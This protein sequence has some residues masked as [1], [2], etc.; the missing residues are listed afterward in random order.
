MHAHKTRKQMKFPSKRK[1]SYT[2]GDQQRLC[3]CQTALMELY[4]VFR[5]TQTQKHI[6]PN[7]PG[8]S[9]LLTKATLI[10]NSCFVLLRHLC[11]KRIK[12]P[13]PLGP[14]WQWLGKWHDF[15]A[16]VAHTFTFNY[17]FSLIRNV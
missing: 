14:K 5:W 8:I 10:A 2:K 16:I 11:T 7:I 15:L 13:S 12:T 4:S 3:V 1:Q 6:P 17:L 9:C